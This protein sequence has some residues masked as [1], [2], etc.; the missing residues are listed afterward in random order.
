[1][2]RNCWV[3]GGIAAAL[4]GLIGAAV[5]LLGE[6]RRPAKKDEAPDAEKLHEE[7]KSAFELSVS[8]VD[9]EEFHR[10]YDDLEASLCKVKV[11]LEKEKQINDIG[12]QITLLLQLRDTPHFD[13]ACDIFVDNV[14]AAA[15]HY[16]AVGQALCVGK[17]RGLT[18]FLRPFENVEQAVRHV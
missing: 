13:M 2:N 1:M 18:E 6:D 3:G 11:S 12:N 8:P 9:R 17:A 14:K 15:D 7:E 4:L 16:P 5:Y 10:R